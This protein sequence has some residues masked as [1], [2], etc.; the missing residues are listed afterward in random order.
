MLKRKLL[1]ILAL[2]A[3]LGLLPMAPA[4]AQ[5]YVG[6][7][8]SQF[9]CWK[10]A[11]GNVYCAYIKSSIFDD[12]VAEVAYRV[13]IWC[14]VNGNPSNCQI[15]WGGGLM[16]YREDL[17]PGFATY[18]WGTA[19]KQ[20]GGGSDEVI[21][22]G[23]LHSVP[24]TGLYEYVYQTVGSV[25]VVWTAPGKQSGTKTRCSDAMY[26]HRAE[27]TLPYT[28]PYYWTQQWAGPLSC[29]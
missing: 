22:E 8:T 18:P 4:H 3:T 29:L 13:H 20:T 11:S 19:T 14:T 6:P 15:T 26:L 27:D 28:E 24:V 16:R 17:G 21:W 12:S 2:A 10:A 25:N 9:S 1:V 7:A 23:A 5:E